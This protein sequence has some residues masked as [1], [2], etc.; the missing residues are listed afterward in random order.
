MILPKILAVDS[1]DCIYNVFIKTL[2]NPVFETNNRRWIWL[3]VV[4]MKIFRI[5]LV[6]C[7]LNT[8]LIAQEKSTTAS[9]A[10][11]FLVKYLYA[12]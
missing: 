4:R 12:L 1:K 7:V 5:V 3:G 11:F 8:F 9:G 10:D 2:L 6:L